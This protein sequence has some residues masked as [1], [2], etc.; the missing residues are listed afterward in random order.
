[1]ESLC[2]KERKIEMSDETLIEQ[3]LDEQDAD[4]KIVNTDFIKCQLHPIPLTRSRTDIY[5]SVVQL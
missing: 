1:M 2:S 4:I 3:Y 5:I